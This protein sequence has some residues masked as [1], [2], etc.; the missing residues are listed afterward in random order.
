[1]TKRVHPLRIA[2]RQS[3]MAVAQAEKI[4]QQLLALYPELNAQIITMKTRGDKILDTPL[5][6]IGG[7]GLFTKEL[8]V[9]LLEDRADIAVHSIKDMPVELPDGLVMPVVCQ[10]DNPYDA[11]ISPDYQSLAELPAN[12]IV[13]T[14]SL[15]RQVQ[16]RAAYPTLQLSNLRGNVITRLEKLDQGDYDAIIL[17]AAGLARINLEKRIKQIIPASVM[18]PSI[19]QGTVGIE[20]RAGDHT[21]AQLIAPLNEPVSQY[22]IIAERAVNKTLQ[23]GCQVPIAAYAQCHDS[24]LSL[25]A[26]VSSLDGQTILRANAKGPIQH[27]EALGYQVGQDLLTQGAAAILSAVYAEH[28]QSE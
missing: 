23:G 22:C 9:A 17:G 16:I 7:K 2:S 19:A 21:I 18:L 14:S 5:A 8:E 13:G 20:C 4:K 10:R 28:Q 12:A 27:A 6:K 25:Q 26:L 3:V 15:R 1:M 24:Q 11:F